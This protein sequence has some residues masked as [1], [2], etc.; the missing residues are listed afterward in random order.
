MNFLRVLYLAIRPKT[1]AA[2]LCPV[3]MGTSMAL[4]AGFFDFFTFLFT[5][6]TALGIQIGTN[7][8]NDYFD[9]KKG[10]DTAARIGPVRVTQAGLISTT[11]MK[12]LIFINFSLVVLT[13]SFLILKGG[14]VFSFL[15]SFAILFALLYTAGPYSIAYLGLGELFVLIFFGPVAVGS[16][17]YLQA[18]ELS[19]QSCL[20]GLSCGLI[21]SAILLV[22]NIRDVEEDK[23]AN[24]KTLVV[25]FGAQFG[26]RLFAF[27][28]LSSALVPIAFITHSPFILLASLTLLPGFFLVKEVF[29][30]QDPR[31][32]NPI[33]GKTAKFLMVYTLIFC[34]A[35]MV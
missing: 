17:Y 5:L 20:A 2:S 7:L 4:K 3:L 32:F 27:F 13:G 8:A 18:N 29:R 35:W 30:V 34:F 11:A 25:R 1:L 12:K 28:I 23:K 21:S 33:L 16:V 31:L 9:F 24:K 6:L 15:I 22:N 19:L 26:K 10:A 14:V